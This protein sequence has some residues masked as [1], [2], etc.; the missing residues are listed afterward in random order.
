MRSSSSRS[1]GGKDQPEKEKAQRV[2]LNRKERPMKGKETGPGGNPPKGPKKVRGQGKKKPGNQPG[3]GRFIFSKL[4]S[5]RGE[6][7][8]LNKHNTPTE[9]IEGDANRRYGKKT[10]KKK[11]K[12]REWINQD[13]GTLPEGKGFSSTG[14]TS[15]RHVNGEERH[16]EGGSGCVQEK[17]SLTFGNDKT[18]PSG[19]E[20]K[21]KIM[22]TRKDIKGKDL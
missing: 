12:A 20:E 17:N 5:K 4:R 1:A 21:E 11:T 10:Q 2:T 6:K 19:R 3:E 14:R 18:N 16:P 15:Q 13:R 22:E 9:E 8:S 7:R